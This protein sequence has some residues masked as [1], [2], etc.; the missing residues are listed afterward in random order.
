MWC[1]S[2]SAYFKSLLNATIE[3]DFIRQRKKKTETNLK[4]INYNEKRPNGSLF[5][6]ALY[7]TATSPILICVLTLPI[8][9]GKMS[10]LIFTKGAARA[11][12]EL[13]LRD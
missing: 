7:S 1:F 6:S 9:S 12:N 3:S 5:A 8:L 13:F 4:T 2:L 11:F 10:P